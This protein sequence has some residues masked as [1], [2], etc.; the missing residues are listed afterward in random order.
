MHGAARAACV[1]CGAVGSLRVVVGLSGGVDSSV[2]AAR[3]VD[4]G[5]DV[6]GVHLAMA[7]ASADGSARGCAVPGAVADAERVARRLGI[8]FEVWDFAAEFQARVVDDFVAE[9]ARGRTPNPCLR[10][11]ATIKFAALL[12]A[13]RGRG[14]DALATGHYARIARDGEV[15]RLLRSGADKDQSYV[16]AV[17]DQARLRRVLFPLAGDTK[18]RVRAEAAARGLEVADKPDSLDICFIP[19]ADAAGWLAER[20]GPRPGPI[21][22]ERGEVVGVHEGTYRFTVGQRRG[23]RLGRPAP[24]GAPRYVVGIEPETRTVRVGPRAALAVSTLRCVEPT[25]TVAERVGSWRALV[26]VRAHGEPMPATVTSGPDGWTVVLDAPAHGVAPGQGAV[27][28]DGDEVVGAA[29]IE[30]AVA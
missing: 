26:Q 14:F 22:D 3:L 8:G 27:A 9:Y 13:A 23:L 18:T 21:V 28:Y 12:D 11:N 15:V 19:G 5:H 1:D 4:A 6:L 29:T 7:R 25:W 24:E 10:C 17:L 2:A 16:L 20:L 30:E